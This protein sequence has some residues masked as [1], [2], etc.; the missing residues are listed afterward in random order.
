MQQDG[1]VLNNY[2]PLTLPPWKNTL[3]SFE[4]D[5]FGHENQLT[6]SVRTDVSQENA[7]CQIAPSTSPCH[8]CFYLCS[9]FYFHRLK[10][11]AC[12]DDL[13]QINVLNLFQNDHFH[14]APPPIFAMFLNICSF[15]L[16]FLEAKKKQ[17]AGPF[18]WRPVRPTKASQTFLIGQRVFATATLK[19]YHWRNWRSHVARELPRFVACISALSGWFCGFFLGRRANGYSYW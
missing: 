7:R 9:L 8:I 5:P 1:I 15:L 3:D 18:L 19:E 16:H 12:I 17:Q 11:K 4:W 6:S 10:Q 14:E 2:E 13:K